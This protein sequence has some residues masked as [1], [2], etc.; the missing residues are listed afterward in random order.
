MIR[1]F[2][3]DDEQQSGGKILSGNRSPARLPPSGPAH[4]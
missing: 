3:L 2:R 4:S 1:Q